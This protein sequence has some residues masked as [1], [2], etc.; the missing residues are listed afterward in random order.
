MQDS[1]KRAKSEQHLAIP[2]HISN[3]AKSLYRTMGLTWNES[4]LV[5]S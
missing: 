2:I 1:E 4:K 3:H 5:L